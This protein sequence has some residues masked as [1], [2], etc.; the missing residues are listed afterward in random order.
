[1][2]PNQWKSG[3]AHWPWLFQLHTS[4]IPRLVQ[5]RNVL[6]RKK[7]LF[8]PRSCGRKETWTKRAAAMQHKI[9]SLQQKHTLCM[10]CTLPRLPLAEPASENAL[11]RETASHAASQGHSSPSAKVPFK[12]PTC[13]TTPPRKRHLTEPACGTAPLRKLPLEEPSCISPLAEKPTRTNLPAARPPP[14]I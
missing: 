4:T 14:K 12:Q 7:R 13:D 9:Y 3:S 10:A 6:W 8:R 11:S 2:G 1:M 5:Q